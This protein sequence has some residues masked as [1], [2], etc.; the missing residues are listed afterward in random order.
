MET[1]PNVMEAVGADTDI[2]Y[3]IKTPPKFLMQRVEDVVELFIQALN[4]DG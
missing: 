1:R 4:S 2:V 3:Q